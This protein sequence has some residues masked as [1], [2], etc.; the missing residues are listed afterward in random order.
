MLCTWKQA[1]EL[2]P[3]NATADDL[4][5]LQKYCDTCPKPCGAQKENCVITYTV[6]FENFWK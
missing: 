5:A 2:L 6:K 1:K 4:L 3:K